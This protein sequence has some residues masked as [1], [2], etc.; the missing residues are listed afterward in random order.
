MF[1]IFNPFSSFHS[2]GSY[3]KT[4]F[5]AGNLNNPFL[6]VSSSTTMQK[7]DKF[8]APLRIDHRDYCIQTNNQLQSPHCAG[9]AAA[10]YGEVHNWIKKHYPEQIDA[11]RI[12][13]E[14]KRLDGNTQKGTSLDR[15]AQALVNLGYWEGEPKYVG[16]G[17]NDIKFAIHAYFVCMAGFLITNE[18]NCVD[19]K[20]GKI[21]DL[22]SKAET[23]GGHAVLCCGYSE[24][25]G[26]YIQNSWGHE[27]GLWGF[28]IIPWE[29]VDEQL[30]YAFVID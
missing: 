28:G 22:G 6:P 7:T 10:G 9:Y 13:E 5:K 29:K 30:M 23:I 4:N 26:V 14:A 3:K 2:M 25:E 12:Y 16:M 15:A 1:N 8:M 24:H 27:W 21:S 11:D 18:W 20:T 17:R 19:S